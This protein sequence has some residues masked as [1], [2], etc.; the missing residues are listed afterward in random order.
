MGGSGL[1]R[2]TP[3]VFARDAGQRELWAALDRVSAT[4]KY[5][6]D[7]ASVQARGLYVHGPV[8]RGK[9]WIVGKWFDAYPGTTKLRVHFHAF[10]EELQR[11]TFAQR[12]TV[13]PGQGDPLTA[14][15]DALVG[16]C[17][18]LYFDEFH[19]H[20]PGDAI[21]LTRVLE[22]LFE[23]RVVV[24]ATSNYAPQELMPHPGWHHLFQPAITLI[25]EHLDV[26]ELR[27]PTDYRT[28]P[29]AS[30]SGGFAAGRWV[31]A[32]RDREHPPE[33][34]L[35]VRGR[36]FQ[37]AAA[38]DTELTA[39]FAQLCEA[40]LST[41]EYLAWAEQFAQ[42]VL[43]DVPPGET[44]DAQA[45]QRFAHVIDVLTEADVQLT[46]QAAQPVDVFVASAPAL[47]DLARMR[48]R[49]SVLS[50]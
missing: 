26:V 46:V 10:L 43:L 28:L 27:G 8:G 47:P 45:F 41:I 34:E 38:S 2:T 7:A 33:T 23:R 22:Y 35:E 40:P 49:L 24:L 17:R 3:A 13:V 36:R 9:S 50:V 1:S 4:W 21:L 20:D 19:V 31:V 5:D 25:V 44:V 48:S 14:A 18:L 39:T 37:V 11:E 42:W 15:F 29:S 16:G 32:S 6:D 30:G 12:Q